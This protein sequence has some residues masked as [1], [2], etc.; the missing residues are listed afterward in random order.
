MDGDTNPIAVLRIVARNRTSASLGVRHDVYAWQ[1]VSQGGQIREFLDEGI[2]MAENAVPPGTVGA[3]MP[4]LGEDALDLMKRYN[5][6]AMTGVLVEDSHTGTLT[7]SFGAPLAKYTITPY[8]HERFLRGM[9][10]LATLH[11]EM[12]ADQ[13]ILPF[14]NFHVAHG[15]DDLA[16]IRTSQ[17]SR[18]TDAAVHRSPDGH[19]PDGQLAR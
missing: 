7:R 11:F 2:L 14:S 12:G 8:D 10:H 19:V 13:V 16:R 1:G 5:A 15:V 18:S 3:Q 6:M 4:F 9:H 17:R